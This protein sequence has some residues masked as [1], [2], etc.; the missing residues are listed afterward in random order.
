MSVQYELFLQEG[1]PEFK[2]PTNL[3]NVSDISFQSGN[4]LSLTGLQ[5]TKNCYAIWKMLQKINWNGISRCKQKIS[6]PISSPWERP[7]HREGIIVTG[8]C[9]L[10]LS[11]CLFLRFSMFDKA[12][13][14][15]RV[16]QY[17]CLLL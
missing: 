2:I 10:L 13:I 7:R 5:V 3:E 6:V 16:C 11:Q 14:L 8:N 17:F 12:M 9:E 1:I 4:A 15:L